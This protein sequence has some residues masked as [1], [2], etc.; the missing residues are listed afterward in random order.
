[1]SRRHVVSLADG[2]LT[3]CPKKRAAM[4]PPPLAAVRHD[5]G[6]L[7]G[8]VLPVRV[9]LSGLPARLP[10]ATCGRWWFYVLRGTRYALCSPGERLAENRLRVCCECD[11]PMVGP[12]GEHWW[13]S[14][15][16]NHANS[17]P[18]PVP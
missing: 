10:W 11:A 9:Y 6:P 17:L 15:D 13:C 7:D 4:P 2:T 1:L 18:D 14:N 8:A 3:L 12:D 5:G 16:V